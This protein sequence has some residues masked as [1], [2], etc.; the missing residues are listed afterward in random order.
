LRGCAYRQDFKV[1]DEAKAER[2]AEYQRELD[3]MPE[4][5]KPLREP[6][7]RTL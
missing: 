7:I 3:Q 1:Y 2:E 6:R 5:A 4:R